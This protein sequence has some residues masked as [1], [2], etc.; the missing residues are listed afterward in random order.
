MQLFWEVGWLSNSPLGRGRGGIDRVK[1]G[2]AWWVR[3]RSAFWCRGGRE[4]GEVDSRSAKKVCQSAI[5][6]YLKLSLKGCGTLS[7]KFYRKFIKGSV[8]LDHTS[9]FNLI[10]LTLNL[11]LIKGAYISRRIPKVLD[12]NQ[13]LSFITVCTRQSNAAFLPLLAKNM[14]PSSLRVKHFLN[15]WNFLRWDWDSPLSIETLNFNRMQNARA[16]YDQSC[17]LMKKGTHL[18][19]SVT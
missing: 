19:E 16:V 3:D 17:S 10:G 13:F 4:E 8:K 15:W 18:Y 1:K 2:V 7:F 11:Q 14:E 9:R 5:V 6:S 12:T